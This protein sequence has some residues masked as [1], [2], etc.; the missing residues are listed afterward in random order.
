M[1]TP[2]AGAARPLTNRVM[3]ASPRMAPTSAIRA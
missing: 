2:I 3:I 1:V